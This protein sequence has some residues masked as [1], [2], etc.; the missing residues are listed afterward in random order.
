M[1]A[2]IVI[3][4]C[5][6]SEKGPG[7]RATPNILTPGT[8]RA[9]AHPRGNERSWATS[10]AKSSGS[11]MLEPPRRNSHTQRAFPTKQKRTNRA[12]CDA[13]VSEKEKLVET[14]YQDSPK[15]PNRPRAKG[16][17]GHLHVVRVG[18]GGPHFGIRRL[19]LPLWWTEEAQGRRRDEQKQTELW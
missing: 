7:F 1:V 4:T 5:S 10:C 12:N 8:V 3:T 16:V 19:I 13:G 6:L 9:H 11:G 14:G 2:I 17:D 18:D 15:E